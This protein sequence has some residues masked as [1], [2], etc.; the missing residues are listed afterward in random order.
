MTDLCH[1]ADAKLECS[2]LPLKP[3][4]MRWQ[5]QSRLA[6]TVCSVRVASSEDVVLSAVSDTTTS[7][8]CLRKACHDPVT[9]VTRQSRQ[10]TRGQVRSPLCRLSSSCQRLPLPPV[11][12]RT[13]ETQR[14]KWL[15]REEGCGGDKEE[16]DAYKKGNI[17]WWER[18]HEEEF[19]KTEGKLQ[20]QAVNCRENRDELWII[21]LLSCLTA[22]SKEGML[23]VQMSSLTCGMKY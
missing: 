4:V 5:V 14:T 3:D 19:K 17:W 9:P 18:K 6:V 16:E 15:K 10:L 21:L 12:H 22:V 20:E 8:T 7:Q 23:P 1:I 11:W 13:G 2:A